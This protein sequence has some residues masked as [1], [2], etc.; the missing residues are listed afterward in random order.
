MTGVTLV[1]GLPLLLAGAMIS[2]TDVRI[3][4]LADCVG[5]MLIALPFVAWRTFL[6]AAI[7]APA[8]E[9][10][11]ASLVRLWIGGSLLAVAVLYFVGSVLDYPSPPVRIAP[12]AHLLIPFMPRA[13]LALGLFCLSMLVSCGC[14]GVLA[15]LATNG[16]LAA[17]TVVT[18]A[19]VTG[20]GLFAVI[21][22]AG[23]WLVMT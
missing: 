15:P 19:T 2:P 7:F 14:W 12:D 6:I 3:I 20:L 1:F 11:F 16:V 10:R 18:G 21:Y 8:G 5:V 23:W 9:N 4:G 22:S 13:G 17:E